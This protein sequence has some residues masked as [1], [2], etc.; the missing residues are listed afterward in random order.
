MKYYTE[1]QIEDKKGFC[2]RIIESSRSNAKKKVKALLI[3]HTDNDGMSPILLFNYLKFLYSEGFD[4]DEVGIQAGKLDEYILNDLN[5]E[6]NLLEYDDIFIVDLN[7]RDDKV[8]SY[9]D[10]LYYNT[11]INIVLLDHHPYEELNDYEWCYVSPSVHTETEIN[12]TSGTSLLCDFISPLISIIMMNK[13]TDYVSYV[14]YWDTFEWKRTE[15][16]E[17]AEKALNLNKIFS[18]I[19]N[20]DYFDLITKMYFRNMPSNEIKSY[21]F[22]M[23]L[24]VK[25]YDYGLKRQKEIFEKSLVYYIHKNTKV[26]IGVGNFSNVSILSSQ[27][28]NDNKSEIL[29]LYDANHNKICIRSSDSCKYDMKKLAIL[30]GGGGH[31]H[32]SGATTEAFPSDKIK[33]I[34]IDKIKLFME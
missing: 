16:K 6:Y 33:D 31:Y 23:D 14:T 24:L 5:K 7:L 1:K 15:N 8:I 17:L 27:L 10:F 11:D 13:I 12:I 25:S 28:L 30:F 9:L 32:A 3:H 4:F 18:S 22:A 26:M 19:D 34:I 21:K 29:I 2:E 20:D